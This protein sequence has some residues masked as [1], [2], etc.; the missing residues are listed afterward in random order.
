MCR[1]LRPQRQAIKKVQTAVP[2]ETELVVAV[3][4]ASREREAD[5]LPRPAGRGVEGVAEFSGVAIRER[6]GSED[7]ASVRIPRR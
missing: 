6:S 1:P 2:R 3:Q 5:R 4:R 7:G